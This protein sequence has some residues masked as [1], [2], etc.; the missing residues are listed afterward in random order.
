MRDVG[1]DG[2]VHG[3]WENTITATMLFPN[4]V[5]QVG[6][7]SFVASPRQ[8]ALL[9][10]DPTTDAAA[11]VKEPAVG[12]TKRREAAPVDAEPTRTSPT[13]SAL[14]ATVVSSS[15]RPFDRSHIETQKHVTPLTPLDRPMF[16]TLLPLQLSQPSQDQ[17]SSTS[18]AETRK[19]GAFV[20]TPRLSSSTEHHDRSSDIY[21][22]NFDLLSPTGAT[23]QGGGEVSQEL[24]VLLKQ[25]FANSICHFFH[26]AARTR[27]PRVV[28][29]RGWQS[30]RQCWQSSSHQLKNISLRHDHVSTQPQQQRPR[31]IM[32][33]HL[34][35]YGG[36]NS[37]IIRGL[38]NYG[39]T[40]FLNAVL[41][42]LASLEPFL[43]YLDTIT[44]NNHDGTKF[45]SSQQQPPPPMAGNK[46]VSWSLLEL[47][48]YINGLECDRNYT[49]PDPRD[50]LYL[51]ACQNEQFQSR[52]HH[53]H[54]QSNSNSKNNNN[55]LG[56]EQ[57][58]AQ[59]LLQTLLD[60]I[61]EEV[62]VY[63]EGSALLPPL[64]DST[65]AWLGGQTE[66]DTNNNNNNMASSLSSSS[67]D[68]M[69][70][71]TLN[72]HGN[73]H[74]NETSN[75]AK[76]TKSSSSASPG[77]SMDDEKKQNE[78]ELRKDK[79]DIVLHSRQH[80]PTTATTAS[81]STSLTS[82][83][84]SSSA[85]GDS[86]RYSQD[87]DD[88]A[89]QRMVT[90]PLIKP[91]NQYHPNISYYM[92]D[93][94]LVKSSP[95]YPLLLPLFPHAPESPM[96]GWIGSTLQCCKCHYIRPIQNSPF[97][98]IPIVPT[99]LYH[100]ASSTSS[101]SSSSSLCYKQ[102]SS[103]S[104]AQHSPSPLSRLPSCTVEQCLYDFCA[105]ERVQDVECLA[106]TKRQVKSKLQEDQ[107]CLRA[108]IRAM[109]R[110]HS[111]GS[112]TT[113]A[114]ATQ[115]GSVGL[116]EELKLVEHVL[117]HLDSLDMEKLVQKIQSF[118]DRRTS[119]DDDDSYDADDQQLW[120]LLSRVTDDDNVG[121]GDAKKCWILTRLP[122]ILCLHVQRR[123]YDHTTN[124][125]AKTIQH[126]EFPE[127]L[128]VSPYF[129]FGSSLFPWVG[130]VRMPMSSS[131]SNG[132]ILYRL[133]SV[134]EH[135]G[136]AFA[137]HYIS[138]RRDQFGGWV[139]ASDETVTRVSWEQVRQC[140][141]YMLFY[142][143]ETHNTTFQ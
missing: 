67:L 59:E 60:M 90:A 3:T 91:Q 49:P 33:R 24:I 77:S 34:E 114:A 18:C 25:C 87:D 127:L 26:S 42:S 80:G 142:Q 66:G 128:D 97:L 95:V 52:Q 96:H 73:G 88:G 125:M 21:N 32:R 36:S 68:S 94:Y 9:I 136:D 83:S 108:A 35:H 99:S 92:D 43:D 133:Q 116:T 40:C 6:T 107:D 10:A 20:T 58:D 110:K 31:K 113:S 48:L 65:E 102:Q 4:A 122:S 135:R 82:S 13:H 119:D 76:T 7:A 139:R 17:T 104:S 38:C 72:T 143:M 47:L 19:D 74:F 141:A 41:Q 50:I 126:V 117:A 71:E 56:K 85:G 132:P 64:C 37:G 112:T 111:M 79:D 39:Q 1:L 86:S 22:I 84:S 55:S 81:L 70:D 140:Q 138:Y 120:S 89:S 57:Q 61:L 123:F 2:L 137:G 93:P 29:N 98:D 109:E 63:L 53:H 69:S 105:V 121:R 27:L 129:A 54:Q 124:R 118:R 62:Q 16:T 134:L 44:N 101:S 12:L 23:N 115:D 30:V 14:T 51:V 8:S 46:N 45:S 5:I 131:I 78:F 106:C 103:S 130:T 100:V 11:V 15:S 75:H 28:T